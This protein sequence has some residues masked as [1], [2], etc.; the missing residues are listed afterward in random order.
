MKCVDCFGD[1]CNAGILFRLIFRPKINFKAEQLRC[2]PLHLPPKTPG[3]FVMFAIAKLQ[4]GTLFKFQL[5]LS[6]LPE[7]HMAG[8]YHSHGGLLRCGAV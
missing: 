8:G 2:L 5:Q 7:I 6:V 1:E 3:R 4:V